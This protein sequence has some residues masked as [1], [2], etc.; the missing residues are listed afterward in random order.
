MI[1]RA[2]KDRTCMWCGYRDPSVY[3]KDGQTICAECWK[4]RHGI[5]ATDIHHLYGR[6]RDETV[7]IP[8]NPHAYLTQKHEGWPECLKT[9][10]DEPL[11][12]IAY[13]LRMALDLVKWLLAHQEELDRLDTYDKFFKPYGGL[14]ALNGIFSPAR[15]QVDRMLHRIALNL[16]KCSD[17][18]IAL[19]L[20]LLKE[21]GPDYQQQLDIAPL[22]LTPNGKDK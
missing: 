2:H 15:Y 6:S 18:L 9:F 3:R 7:E 12:Q 20:F 14:A 13:I 21:Y 10:P 19:R 8:A 5:A 17:W 11:L 22:L 4:K 16:E 1:P